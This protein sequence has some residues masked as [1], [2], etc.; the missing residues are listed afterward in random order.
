VEKFIGDAVVGVFGVPTAQE[1]DALRASMKARQ[2]AS[3][4]SGVVDRRRSC[5]SAGY[6]DWA[7]PGRGHSMLQ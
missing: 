7:F 5:R 4:A 6:E 2:E 3:I 1:D